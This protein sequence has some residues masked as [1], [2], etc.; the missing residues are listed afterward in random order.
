METGAPGQPPSLRGS[1]PLLTRLALAVVDQSLD[2]LT[3]LRRGLQG[4]R[5]LPWAQGCRPVPACFQGPQGLSSSPI[6]DGPQPASVSM[7][8]GGQASKR[9][10]GAEGPSQA[11]MW[12]GAGPRCADPRQLSAALPLLVR[13]GVKASEKLLREGALSL[14]PALT[15]LEKPPAFQCHACPFLGTLPG[16][17]GR[18]S[19]SISHGYRGISC[20]HHQDPFLPPEPLFFGAGEGFPGAWCPELLSGDLGLPSPGPVPPFTTCLQGPRPSMLGHSLVLRL[21]CLSETP[22]SRKAQRVSWTGL[23]FSVVSFP[24]F[25]VILPFCSL[26]SSPLCLRLS[27]FHLPL[28][29]HAL[30]SKNSLLLIC[31][32]NTAPLPLRAGIVVCFWVIPTVL[33]C[34][35]WR[36]SVSV[37]GIWWHLAFTVFKVMV[38]AL[39][40]RAMTDRGW[41]LTGEPRCFSARSPTSGT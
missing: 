10:P 35:F 27:Y 12:G 36:A 1:W 3:L 41:P 13:V 37:F 31:F 6:W 34:P 18:A 8:G 38:G 23:D 7:H 40:Q 28:C 5:A 21:S 20:R 33:E 30:I 24:T 9:A 29:Y 17:G 22:V 16:L 25:D 39:T 4:G 26:L 14:P 11:S 15:F 2:P 32:V 19:L